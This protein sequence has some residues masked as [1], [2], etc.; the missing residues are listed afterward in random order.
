MADSNF[1]MLKRP[2]TRLELAVVL[3]LLI[4]AG[5][6]ATVT[7]AYFDLIETTAGTVGNPSSGNERVYGDS[8]THT[9]SCLTSSG[10][11]CAP[12][13]GGGGVTL[14]QIGVGLTSLNDPNGFTYTWFNQASS[15]IT[16]NGASLVLTTPTSGGNNLSGRTTA[17]T[18]TNPYTVTLGMIPNLYN[19][20]SMQ[21]GLV[22]TNGSNYI[23]MRYRNDTVIDIFTWT[24]TGT[25]GSQLFSSAGT[26]ALTT[27]YPIIFL[28]IQETSTT[29]FYRGG[30]DGVNFQN[31]FNEAKQ[32]FITTT[33]AGFFC[34]NNTS[35]SFTAATTVVHFTSSAP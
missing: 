32:T 10:G 13:G 11:S 31:F 33:R 28:Q 19:A 17:V 16:T 29:R 1:K 7:N 5:V 26:P 23:V 20:S 30:T 27:P 6:Y 2:I 14:P 15:T 22:I 21:C 12:S 34:L 8:G 25:P 4:A 9:L 24:G 18:G 35:A 3:A